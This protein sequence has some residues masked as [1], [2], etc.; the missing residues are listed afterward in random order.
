MCLTLCRVK[1]LCRA[2]TPYLTQFFNLCKVC[3]PYPVQGVYPDRVLPQNLYR[4]Q[5]PQQRC[6]RVSTGCDPGRVFRGHS[7]NVHVFV[8]PP[9][10]WSTHHIRRGMTD[11]GL[12]PVGCSMG[13][14]PWDYPW[15]IY[16]RISS[17]AYHGIYPMVFHGTSRGVFHGRLPPGYPEESMYAPYEIM[18]PHWGTPRDTPW[19]LTGYPIMENA[20]PLRNPAHRGIHHGATFFHGAPQWSFVPW[21]TRAKSSQCGDVHTK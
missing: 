1:S 20:H 3:S 21:S 10:P 7:Q 17:A 15:D 4:V 13:S 19:D 12:R 16:H 9:Y 6:P 18:V 8:G 5:D 11:G 2:S 14:V